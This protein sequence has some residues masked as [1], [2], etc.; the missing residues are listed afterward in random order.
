MVDAAAPRKIAVGTI[1]RFA[2]RNVF[3]RLELVPE[4]GWIMLLALLAVSI[5]PGLVLPV[6]HAGEALEVDPQDY[7][8]AAV[9]LLALSAFA[10]RWHQSILLGDPRR[11][12]VAVF[13][14]GWAR[15]LVYGCILYAA[16]GVLV[17]AAAIGLAR[18]NGSTTAQALILF[19]ALVVA[20]LVLMATA[21]CALVFPAAACGKP[22]GLGTAWQ[23]MR[24][25]SWRL[26]W[27]S[28]LTALP[29]KVAT[30]ILTAIVVALVAPDGTAD[31]ANP[32][33]GFVIL[34]GLIEAISDILLAALGASVLSGFYR[35]LV[36]WRGE[37]APASD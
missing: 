7:V 11:Q 28:L 5:V 31:L 26:I 27:A 21:R 36:A 37:T 4:L 35:E 6:R 23:L 22:I 32:P 18:M 9:A 14:R 19:A 10:V 2:Y 25:N 34:L 12:P 15:F 17:A 16:L 29:L 24:G 20:W 1:A 33:M 8:Q 13:F 30:L 3:G